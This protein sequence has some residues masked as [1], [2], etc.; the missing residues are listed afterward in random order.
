MSPTPFFFCTILI[1]LRFCL[2]VLCS[3]TCMTVRLQCS[4]LA[5]RWDFIVMKCNMVR[6][7]CFIGMSS[8]LELLRDPRYNKGLAFTEEER[9]HHY[10]R[11]LLPP[12][13]ISQELQVSHNLLQNSLLFCS[14]IEM[15]K[16]IEW[17]F[18]WCSDFLALTMHCKY[19]E[20]NHQLKFLIIF[21]VFVFL[22]SVDLFGCCM[23]WDIVRWL[24]ARWL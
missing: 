3:S 14:S 5:T 15:W 6:V 2:W 23:Q 9:D 13:I 24:L 10:L 11:G 19:S 20:Y 18:G 12:A 17:G 21:G 22:C 8:G 4:L 1:I 16:W 7:V